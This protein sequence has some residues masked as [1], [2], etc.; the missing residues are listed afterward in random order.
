MKTFIDELLEKGREEG[1]EEAQ[2]SGRAEMAVQQLRR[3]F[4]E[5]AVTKPMAVR[6]GKLPLARL[7][8]LGVEL[9][10]FTSLA[11]LKRWLANH[12]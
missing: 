12:E 1:R 4:G 8:E 7:K 2:G 10:D 3:K 11:D 5:K 6:I 9:L